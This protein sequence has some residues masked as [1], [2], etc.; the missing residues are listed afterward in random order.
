MP[1]YEYKCSKCGTVTEFLESA[2]VS[3]K[4]LRHLCGKC[5]SGDMIKMFSAFAVGVKRDGTDGKCLGCSDRGCPH[6][7]G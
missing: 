1:I 4:K 5:G 3:D 7:Q 6:S 2:D